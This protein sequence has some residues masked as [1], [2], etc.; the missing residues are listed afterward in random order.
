MGIARWRASCDP[1]QQSRDLR[2][3]E[4]RI[5]REVSEPRI[6]EPRRHHSAVHRFRDSGRPRP[7]LLIRQQGHGSDFAGAV[8]TLAMALEQ[9][10]DV[11]VESGGAFFGCRRCGGC[12]RKGYGENDQ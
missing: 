7:G 4:R 2:S 6:S 10:E 3:A 11:L 12:N 8:T 5:V 9:G 1:R